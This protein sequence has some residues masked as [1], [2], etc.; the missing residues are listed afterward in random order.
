MSDNAELLVAIGRIEEGM[1]YMRESMERVERKLGSHDD[2][3]TDVEHDVI[4]LKTQR[5]S[6][7]NGLT[8]FLQ[9][10]LWLLRLLRLW[11]SFGK[12]WDNTDSCLF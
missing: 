9:L 4:E 6:K 10:W 5:K 3:L 7:A 12:Y 8:I 1:R 11:F 2:R